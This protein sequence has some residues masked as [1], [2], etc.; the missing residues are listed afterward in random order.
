ML[1][2]I[3]K[4]VDFLRKRIDQNPK[5]AII[6]GSGLGKMAT[7]IKEKT[8]VPYNE[9]P[10]F[11]ATT[12][13]GHGGNLIFGKLENIPIV[14]MQGRFHYYEGYDM[15]EI[16]F[17]VRVFNELGIQHLILSNASGGVNPDFKIGDIMIIT[18]HINLMPD[19]PLRGKNIDQ[20]GPR[21]PDM[22]EVYNPVLIRKAIDIARKHQ[23]PFRT[24]VYAA[25][26]G[27]TYETPSEYHYI[28]TIGADAV[29]MSTVPE[30]IVAKHMGLSCF[31]ISVITDL[32]VTGKIVELTHQ[33]VIEAANKVEPKMVALLRELLIESVI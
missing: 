15:K 27:P 31:A 28:R 6:L 23:I 29:G 25:V 12:V 18:D 13:E 20:L 22:S 24:G 17:P 4:T 8:I 10:N 19:N 16:T 21:F 14:A 1:A 5:V 26:M 2:K 30:A 7:D 33:D 9:I 11:P 3:Q 32:G